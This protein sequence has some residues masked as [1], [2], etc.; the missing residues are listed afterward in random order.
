MTLPLAQM[1]APGQFR[2]IPPAR[3]VGGEC[4]Y[5]WC[6]GAAGCKRPTPRSTTPPATLTLQLAAPAASTA[7]RAARDGGNLYV[8]L[9]G[10]PS[11]VLDAK[12][13][14]PPRSP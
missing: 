10:R 11:L 6:A 8:E 14:A 2:L 7:Q 9:C 5:G 3:G 1:Y 12:G 4:R 13:G